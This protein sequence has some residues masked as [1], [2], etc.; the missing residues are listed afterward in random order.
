MLWYFQSSKSLYHLT[1]EDFAQ[2]RQAAMDR[3]KEMLQQVT[4]YHEE[5]KGGGKYNSTTGTMF[6]VCLLY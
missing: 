1:S 3:V 6:Y 4:D 5:A 2:D